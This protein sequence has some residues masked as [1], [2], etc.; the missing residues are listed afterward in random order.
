MKYIA[1]LCI[2]LAI[3]LKKHHLR[4]LI[5]ARLSI[6]HN[7]GDIDETEAREQVEGDHEELVYGHVIDCFEQFDVLVKEQQDETD[8]Q[9]DQVDGDHSYHEGDAEHLTLAEFCSHHLSTQTLR[10]RPSCSGHLPLLSF[11]IEL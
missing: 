7:G 8:Y 11:N 2:Y 6:A 3:L 5:L 1:N 9:L 4:G 10:A